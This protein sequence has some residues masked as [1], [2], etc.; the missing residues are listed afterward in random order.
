MNRPQDHDRPTRSARS[1]VPR[2]ILP[3]NLAVSLQHLSEQDLLRLSE[4][5]RAEQQRRGLVEQKQQ[6]R[7]TG[8]NNPDPILS[9]LT[10]SQISLICS[11]IQA[12]VKPAA[13]SRQFGLT[14]A[15]IKAALKANQ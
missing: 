10:R 5:V 13:L 9:Q 15:Q 6:G 3:Q 11:S 14:R 4:A 1:D 8:K 7:E 2:T 12:G